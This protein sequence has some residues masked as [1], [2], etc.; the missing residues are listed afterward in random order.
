MN[1]SQ[2]KPNY[3]PYISYSNKSSLSFD[4]MRSY[5][6]QF[7]SIPKVKAFNLVS[8]S[9][10]DQNMSLCDK[11]RANLDEFMGCVGEINY[12]VY[13]DQYIL[14][15]QFDDKNLKKNKKASILAFFN[16][17]PYHVPPLTLNLVS[18]SLLKY[19]NGKGSIT[20]INNPLPRNLEERVTDLMTK[21]QIGKIHFSKL[22]SNIFCIFN[23]L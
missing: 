11:F 5:S 16:N 8:D 1:I 14:G 22:K 21:T 20:V 18:N 15:A 6:T 12:M 17:Q 23:Y 7:K 4:L 2:Y 13:T 9:L 10:D 3:V 19:F